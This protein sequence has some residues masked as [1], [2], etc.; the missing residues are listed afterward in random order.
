MTGDQNTLLLEEIYK[1]AKMGQ[2]AIDFILQKNDN[3]SF[4]NQLSDQYRGYMKIATQA[5]QSLLAEGSTPK[6]ANLMKKGMLWGSVQANTLIDASTQKLAEIMINGSTMGVIEMT[7]KLGDNAD[8]SP[9]TKSLCKNFIQQE[10]QNIDA[11]KSY[12][13]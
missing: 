2:Q 12:L 5:H 3:K 8:A 7:K 1:G 13:S 11:L 9:T 4:A 6:D 10:E